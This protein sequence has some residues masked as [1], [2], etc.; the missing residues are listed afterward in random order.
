MLLLSRKTVFTNMLYN[1]CPVERQ[2]IDCFCLANDTKREYNKIVVIV[3][4]LPQ[5]IVMADEKVLCF[6]L[7]KTLFS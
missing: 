7:I 5:N 1:K 3:F 2:C 6:C 4:S